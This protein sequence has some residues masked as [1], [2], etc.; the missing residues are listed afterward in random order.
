MNNSEISRETLI[1]EAYEAKKNAYVPYSNFP[2]GAALLTEDG[3]IYRGCNIEN[4]GIHADKL[5]GTYRFFLRQ[6]RRENGNFVPLR[7]LGIP[8]ITCS[9]AEYADRS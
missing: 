1:G 4:C 7:W 8:E 2:V 6:Y 9:H 5:R 3:K